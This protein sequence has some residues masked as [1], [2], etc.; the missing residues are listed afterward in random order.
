M[1][2]CP[3]PGI[4]RKEVIKMAVK[5]TTKNEVKTEKKVQVFIP[6]PHDVTGDN[7]TVVSVNGKMYQI[8]YD[9]PVWVPE[10]V[11]EIIKESKQLRAKI[12]EKTKEAAMVPGKAALAEL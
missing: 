10:N 8:M 6:R 4:N 2:A 9:T 12:L 5:N 3:H 1:R 11:A 7:E